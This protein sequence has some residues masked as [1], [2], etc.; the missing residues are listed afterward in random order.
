[1]RDPSIAVHKETDGRNFS[2]IPVAEGVTFVTVS[3][4]GAGSVQLTLTV[5]P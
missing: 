5:G 4:S 3:T 1:M 2:Y